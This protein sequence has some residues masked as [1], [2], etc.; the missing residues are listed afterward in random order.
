[1]PDA[2]GEYIG[3]LA[4]DGDCAFET[5]PIEIEFR[6]P[7]FEVKRERAL[8]L[9]GARGDANVYAIANE[10][11]RSTITEYASG[12]LKLDIPERP[13]ELYVG[14]LSD[15]KAVLRGRNY[16]EC[17]YEISWQ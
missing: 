5:G 17:T 9:G 13:I 7:L 6:G 14:K 11:I 8:M 1:M 4:A 3:S 2:D 12:R 10:P 15:S 16:E